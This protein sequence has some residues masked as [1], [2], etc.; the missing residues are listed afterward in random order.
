M[1]EDWENL[2]DYWCPD[3]DNYVLLEPNK[4][5]LE[6]KCALCGKEISI[7]GGK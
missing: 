6:G 5:M 1:K 2:V 4:G 3:C 7:E